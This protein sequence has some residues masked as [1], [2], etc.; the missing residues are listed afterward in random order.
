MI[1]VPLLNPKFAT[2]FAARCVRTSGSGHQYAPACLK[3]LPGRG[4]S[5]RA[6][7]GG[8][9]FDAPERKRTQSGDASCRREQFGPAVRKT[10][11]VRQF[12]RAFGE[13]RTLRERNDRPS[14]ANGRPMIILA[15]T[16]S[17][18]RHPKGARPLEQPAFT[19]RSIDM[20]S[21]VI[22]YRERAAEARRRAAETRD[23]SIKSAYEQMARDWAMLAEQVEW[24][25]NQR[26]SP[27]TRKKIGRAHV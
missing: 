4:A 1:L 21:R 11:H 23:P 3:L 20:I 2:A 16:P 8:G 25:E 13:F 19:P 7:G 17:A 10:F 5:G 14:H 6:S 26:R 12:Y 22:W 15:E 27:P 18:V 24:I 9:F